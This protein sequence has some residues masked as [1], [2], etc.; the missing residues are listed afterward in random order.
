MKN[1]YRRTAASQHLVIGVILT[2]IIGLGLLSTVIMKKV[3]FEDHFAIPWAAGRGWL[4][5]GISPYAD[6]VTQIANHTLSESTYQAQ[7][8]EIEVLTDPILNLVFILPFS[9]IPYEISRAIWVTAILLCI[10]LIGY[11]GLRLSG[12]KISFPERIGMIALVVLWFPGIQTIIMG[13]SSPIIILLILVGIS[14]ILSEQDTLAGFV[15]A[16]TFGSLPT[17]ALIL[18]LILVWSIS[19]RRWSII[20]S[21]FFGLAFLFIISLM[22]LPSWPLDWLGV[23]LNTY[24]NWDWVR[25]PVM[26]LAALLPGIANYLSIALHAVLGIYLI[27][28]WITLLGKSDSEFTWN[29]LALLVVAYLFHIQ[30]SIHQ[31]LIVIPALFLVFRLWSERWRV[32][33]H[34]LSWLLMLGIV[35]G[36]WYFAAPEFA[37]TD[38]ARFGALIV[39]LPLLVFAGMVWIRWWALKI[40]KLPF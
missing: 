34:G 16:L 17:T 28:L 29:A 24:Q 20:A 26:D 37:F 18:L 9:L 22:L 19:R 33:G 14:A 10:G 4:L 5:E 6:D 7:L 11:F 12:W 21:F 36:S 32:F 38:D 23:L 2:C 1:R 40:P 13:Q 39:G 31:L 27:A 30:S 15:L 35:A 25:T 3:P 8:P